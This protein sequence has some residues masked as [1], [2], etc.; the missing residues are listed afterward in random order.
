MTN[1]PPTRTLHT[2]GHSTRTADELIEMLHE[3]AVTCLVDIRRIPRSRTNPQFNMDVLPA[4]LAREG[5][6]Y[7]QL[8]KLGGRRSKQH[9]P[10]KGNTGWRVKAFE[11]YADYAL[12][13]DFREGLDELLALLVRETCVVMCSEAVWWRCHRRIV[14]DYVLASGVPVVHLLTAT[15]REPA[16]LTPFAVVEGARHISYPP[17]DASP[18]ERT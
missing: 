18:E 8:A 10:V 11:N 16:V 2:V 17:E 9:V 6:S 7:V 4:T 13:A 3:V 1:T 14:S 5:I 15:K 12:S